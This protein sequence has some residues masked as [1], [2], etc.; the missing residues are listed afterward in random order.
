[1]AYKDKS[2]AIAYINQYNAQKYDRATVMLPHGEKEKLKEH[3]A[4]RG[5]SVNAFINRAIQEA[6]ERDNEGRQI[7]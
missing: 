6:M 4:A 2:Q 3:A 1:M 7:E 5:E